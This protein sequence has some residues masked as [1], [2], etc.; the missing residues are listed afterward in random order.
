MFHETTSFLSP[1]LAV[2]HLKLVVFKATP[3][4]T[5]QNPLGKMDQ[6]VF[7]NIINC[8]ARLLQGSITIL[9]DPLV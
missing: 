7:W 8:V 5:T 9:S 1:H 3:L 6:Y 4:N 2:R